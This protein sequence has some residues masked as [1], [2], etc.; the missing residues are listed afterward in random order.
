MK[1]TIFVTLSDNFFKIFKIFWLLF[2]VKSSKPPLKGYFYYLASNLL[3]MH[4][5]HVKHQHKKK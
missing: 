3:N 4:G 2:P 1:V 5:M